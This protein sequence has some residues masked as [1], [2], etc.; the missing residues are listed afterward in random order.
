MADEDFVTNHIQ[1]TLIHISMDS[2]KQFKFPNYSICRYS[3]TC[4]SA[5]RNELNG[6]NTLSFP[7]SLTPFPKKSAG[8]ESFKSVL[9]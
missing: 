1:S 9:H 8:L 4:Y 3:K 7:T 5:V 2:N 6:R